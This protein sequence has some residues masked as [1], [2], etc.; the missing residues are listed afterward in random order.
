M[1]HIGHAMFSPCFCRAWQ[2]EQPSSSHFSSHG[3]MHFFVVEQYSSP[4][5][6]LQPCASRS[7]PAL[8]TCSHIGHAMFS[9]CFCRAW[10]SEQPSSSHFSSH[11]RMHFFVVEQYSSPTDGL[12]PRIEVAPGL[13]HHVL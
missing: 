6:C 4:V 13:E 5:E 11:G 8:S 1:T 9:P 12:Q 2:S 10:Q 7:P 3:R